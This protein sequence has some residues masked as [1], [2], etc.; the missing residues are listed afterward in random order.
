MRDVLRLL[1]PLLIWLA[2]FSAIYGLHGVGCALG[3]AGVEIGGLS[4]FRWALLAAWLAAILVQV[5]LL[6]ALRGARYAAPSPFL[7]WTSVAGAW[8]ALVAVLWTLHPVA[9]LSTC[10]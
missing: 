10:G 2:S 3:W 8:V 5:A 4:L 7:R 1:L 6:L 9:V